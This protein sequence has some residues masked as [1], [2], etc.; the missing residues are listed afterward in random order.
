MPLFLIIWLI[1]PLYS[2]S[3]ASSSGSLP[4]LPMPI[5]PLGFQS[6]CVSCLS[7]HLAHSKEIVFIVWRDREPGPNTSR[8]DT[9]YSQPVRDYRTRLLLISHM[10][11]FLATLKE[12]R[13]KGTD[14]YRSYI[15]C[16]RFG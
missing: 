13:C 16:H 15:L 2:L 7:A 3:S 11:S 12:H 8:R 10:V 5:Y 1:C 6:H 9:L 14:S 4:L